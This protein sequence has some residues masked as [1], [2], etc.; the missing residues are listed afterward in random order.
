MNTLKLANIHIQQSIYVYS[1]KI[2]VL[3]ILH[4]YLHICLFGK[5]ATSFITGHECSILL[6]VFAVC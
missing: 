2:L 1:Y 6:T 3:H 5:R 4:V